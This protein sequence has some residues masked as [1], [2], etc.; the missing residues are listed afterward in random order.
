[1]KVKEIGN[2]TT[3]PTYGE[4]D[5]LK[6]FNFIIAINDPFNKDET[7]FIKIDHTGSIS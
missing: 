6:Y 7:E 3:D 1:M 4:K 2:L 5:D